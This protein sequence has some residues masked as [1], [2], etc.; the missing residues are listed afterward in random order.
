M[1][2][3]VDNVETTA[4]SPTVREQMAEGGAAFA[5]DFAA[6]WNALRISKATLT[7]DGEA[8][9]L[10]LVTGGWSE[11]EAMLDDIPMVWHALFWQSSHRGGLHIYA[12]E[13]ALS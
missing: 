12:R 3:E 13:A 2:D 4:A 1:Q 11:A 10:E 8:W 7:E 9:R 6:R 5:R